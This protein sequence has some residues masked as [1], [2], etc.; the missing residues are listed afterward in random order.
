MSVDGEGGDATPDEPTEERVSKDELARLRRIEETA[1]GVLT[2]M[3]GR[4]SATSMLAAIAAL[5]AALKEDSEP[6]GDG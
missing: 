3:E 2:Q 4:R 6:R 5:R 1:K